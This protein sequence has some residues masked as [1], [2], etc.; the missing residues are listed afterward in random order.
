MRVG[1]FKRLASFLLDAMPIFFILS[2]SLTLFVGDMI[3]SQYPDYDSKAA[4]YQE[5]LD[6]FS[7]MLDAYK[8]QLDENEIT[9]EEYNEIFLELRSDFQNNNEYLY[10]LMLSYYFNVALFYFISFTVI[11]YFYNL[12]FKGQ[13]VG[14]KLMKIELYGRINW[15][16]LFIREVL[17]KSVFWVFTFLVG[18]GLDW[19]LISFTTRKKTIRDYLSNTETRHAGV[20]YPF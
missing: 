7:E 17:W 3:K 9:I 12:A 20:N 6:E 2:L 10:N 4:L 1:F 5:N 14:R 18:I 8:L 19:L 15:Y 13:T 11:N 16:S